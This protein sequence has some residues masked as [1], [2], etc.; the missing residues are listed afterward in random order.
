[1]IYFALLIAAIGCLIIPVSRLM[2]AYMQHRNPGRFSDKFR[3]VY[4]ICV[5]II[6]FT[7]FSIAIYLLETTV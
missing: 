2:M 4:R 6:S 1:M 7:L 5:I 3:Q